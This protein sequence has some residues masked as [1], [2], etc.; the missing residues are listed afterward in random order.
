M[1][2]PMGGSRMGCRGR[3]SDLGPGWA[4]R[5]EWEKGGYPPFGESN[6]YG[7]IGGMG[8]TGD[9]K[10]PLMVDVNEPPVP[11][12]SCSANLRVA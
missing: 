6:E 1:G 2:I 12:A 3:S 4:L 5:V 11:A 9:I 8:S 7:A 10:D